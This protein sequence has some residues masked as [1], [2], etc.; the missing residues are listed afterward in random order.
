MVSAAARRPAASAERTHARTV[1]D[2]HTYQVIVGD[3]PVLVRNNGGDVNE[4]SGGSTPN[5]YDQYVRT[6]SGR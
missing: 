3:A 6:G 1:V 5:D 4:L 2:I